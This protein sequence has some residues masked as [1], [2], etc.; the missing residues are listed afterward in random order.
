MEVGNEMKIFITL[1][2]Y[3]IRQRR[4]DGKALLVVTT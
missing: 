4:K 1:T 2:K 3:N